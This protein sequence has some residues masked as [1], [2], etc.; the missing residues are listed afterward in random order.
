MEVIALLFP[1]TLLFGLGFLI[2]YIWAAKT[3]QFDDIVTPSHRILIDEESD[4]KGEEHKTT[5]ESPEDKKKD[6]KH[7]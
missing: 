7:E 1:M 2:A 3:G 6:L 5:K 4:T